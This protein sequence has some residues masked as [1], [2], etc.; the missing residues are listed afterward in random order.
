MMGSG[1]T[2]TTRWF[3]GGLFGLLLLASGITAFL[4]RLKPQSN[5]QE[6]RQRVK[7]WWVIVFVFALAMAA[8]P[9]VSILFF[10]FVSFL[11]LKENQSTHFFEGNINQ[12]G[13]SND[14]EHDSR[15]QKE[16]LSGRNEQFPP[17]SPP[18][19]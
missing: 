3:L 1:L 2:E 18:V 5:F 9:R 10:A 11:A 4:R 19:K 16:S 7:S 8:S 17:H 15:Q 13:T 12:F 14:T 6:L